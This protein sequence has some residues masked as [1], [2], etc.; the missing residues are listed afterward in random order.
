M[1]MIQEFKEFAVKGNALDLAV[2]LIV[3]V[4][5][6]KIVN[7]IVND[8][9]MPPLGILIGGVDFKNIYVLLK[10]G[11]LVPPPYATL[12]DAQKAGAVTLNIGNFV[13]NVISFLVIVFC[14]FLI[15]Q[16]MNRF[17]RPKVTAAQK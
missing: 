1:G 17:R 16:L 15:V 12:V 4:E 2:G 6:G 3:G 10:A 8:L 7:S 9:I 13:T 11:S 5:F 14:V